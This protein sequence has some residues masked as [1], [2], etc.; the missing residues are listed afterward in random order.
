MAS[1]HAAG[2]IDL[3][4]QLPSVGRHLTPL[5]GETGPALRWRYRREEEVLVCALALTSDATAY[6]LQIVPS[7][8]APG[9]PSEL[10][11]DAIAAF[12]QQARLDRTLLDEGWLLERFEKSA[13]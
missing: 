9:Q 13:R 7:R 12:Q 10:F 11:D 2:D 3:T 4:P 6:E 8:L 5:R 1:V